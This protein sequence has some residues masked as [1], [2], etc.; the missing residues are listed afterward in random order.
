[1]TE[2]DFPNVNDDE[3]KLGPGGLYK[4]L[5]DAQKDVQEVAKADYNEFANFAYA[6]AE[7]ILRE[8]RK[9]LNSHG[10]V[11]RRGSWTIAEEERPKMEFVIIMDFILAHPESGGMITDKF[12]FPAV[13]MKGAPLDKAVAKALTSGLAYWLRDLLLIP[14]VDE[15]MNTRDDS[16]YTPPKRS[17]GT[18]AR[19]KKETTAQAPP[20]PAEPTITQEQEAN[21]IALIEET[22]SNLD[23]FCRAMGV[24]RLSMIPERLYDLAI[25]KLEKKREQS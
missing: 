17:S 2:H 6:S 19:Q 14:R 18:K 5:L 13:I 1:M 7:D 20:Q 23:L 21:I 15:E 16:A 11:A 9:V 24:T 10:L 12:P 8:A 3:S 25:E 4:A 22:G